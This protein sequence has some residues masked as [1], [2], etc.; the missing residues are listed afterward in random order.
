MA[1]E[2]FFIW[3]EIV[4]RS[5]SGTAPGQFTMGS[6]PRAALKKAALQ[7]GWKFAHGETFCCVKCLNDYEA[8]LKTAPS[9]APGDAG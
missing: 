5:C 7:D 4:C 6:T 8:E 9:A 1:S 2:E 3:C